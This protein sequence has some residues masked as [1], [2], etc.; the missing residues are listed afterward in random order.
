AREIRWRG[1]SAHIGSQIVSLSPFRRAFRRISGYVNE[2]KGE[3]IP[4]EYLDFGGGLGVRYTHEKIAARDEYARMVAGIAQ[5]LGL[6]LLLEPGRSII[7]P[8]GGALSRGVYGEGNRG[9]D[10]LLAR[11]AY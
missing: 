5:P 11:R 10:V 2:L 3:G 8:A 4:L 1:I 7:A 9:R 6:H